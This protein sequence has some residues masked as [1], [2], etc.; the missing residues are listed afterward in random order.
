MRVA[1]AFEY[2]DFAKHG[3]KATTSTSLLAQMNTIECFQR[4]IYILF[5]HIF[6]KIILSFRL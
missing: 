5:L 3:I 4:G 1:T 6:E 2:L